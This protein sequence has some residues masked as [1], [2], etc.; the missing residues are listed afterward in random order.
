MVSIYLVE[1]YSAIKK[2]EILLF[3]TTWNDLEGIMLSEASQT[4]TNTTWFHLPVEL[5]NKANEQIETNE[6]IWNRLTNK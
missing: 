6:Q 1:Y 4:K 5:R 2:S 3:A